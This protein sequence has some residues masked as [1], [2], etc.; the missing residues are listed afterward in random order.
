LGL[1]YE[2]QAKYTLAKEQFENTL[3]INPNYNQA[4]E[5]RKMMSESHN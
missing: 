5:I 2:K 3:A 1:A 4:G